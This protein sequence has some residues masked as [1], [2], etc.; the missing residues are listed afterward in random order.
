MAAIP[1]WVY[2]ILGIFMIIS[3]KLINTTSKNSKMSVFFII[4]IIFLAIGIVKYVFAN[5]LEER[6]KKAEAKRQGHAPAAQSFSAQPAAKPE[7][8]HYASHPMLAQLVQRQKA[9]KIDKKID[10][11]YSIEAGHNPQHLS[12]I[13][14]PACGTKHYSYANFCMRCG[15][16]MQR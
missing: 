10:E 2:V 1:G 11:P 5:F 15:T 3:S 9:A 16:K 6:R 7:P 4:G 13:T 14:C 8:A 12:I